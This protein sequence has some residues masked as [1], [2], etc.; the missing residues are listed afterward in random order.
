[1]SARK[2]RNKTQAILEQALKLP[3]AER[4]QI[5][6]HLIASLDEGPDVDVEQAWQEEVQRRIQQIDRGEVQTIPWEEVRRQLRRSR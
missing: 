3:S 5:A 2:K 1:M 4:A 6:E